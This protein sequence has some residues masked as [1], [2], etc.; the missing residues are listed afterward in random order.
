MQY[1]KFI[2][3]VFIFLVIHACQTD[4]KRIPASVESLLTDGN[5][6]VWMIDRVQ[7]AGKNQTVKDPKNKDLLIFYASGHF[8]LQNFKNFGAQL[9]T[10]GR[11]ALDDQ[12]RTLK[13]IFQDQIWVFQIQPLSK[14]KV[15][16]KPLKD[17]DVPYEFLIIPFPELN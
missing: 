16:F 8:V 15:L 10:K 7:I 14:S 4:V 2:L 17:S 5:S 1:L 12:S 13:L 6:K 11:Y 9:P 3:F